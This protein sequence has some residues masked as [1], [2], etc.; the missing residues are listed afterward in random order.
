M[1]RTKLKRFTRVA[2]VPVVLGLIGECSMLFLL[3]DVSRI[4]AV[5]LPVFSKYT[6]EYDR[7]IVQMM[8]ECARYDPEL[9]Y[10]LRPG[11]WRFGNYDFDTEYRVNS[12]GMRDDEESLDAPPVV[13]LGDSFAMGWGVEQNETIADYLEK[14]MD[15]TVLNAGISSYGTS[16]ELKILSRVDRSRLRCV[17]I[18]YCTNDYEENRSAAENSNVLVIS[19]RETYERVSRMAQRRYYFGRHVLKLAQGAFVWPA[20]RLSAALA[21]VDWA[22]EIEKHAKLFVH[23]LAHSPVDL[24][25]VTVVA[26]FLA[27]PST[28]VDGERAT[29]AKAV[30]RRILE[31]ELPPAIAANTIILDVTDNLTR[32]MWLPLAGHLNAK[33]NEFVANALVPFVEQALRE[34]STRND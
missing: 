3:S 31:G 5:L 34:E 1:T 26:V 13:V 20:R 27:G 12:A 22:E 2:V 10:T 11:K 30:R 6:E 29:I 21:G 19:D 9:T 28:E 14:K 32:D 18:Q 25:G 33:G 24:E 4:P 23:T 7:N 17:V 15:V 8:P 16:R